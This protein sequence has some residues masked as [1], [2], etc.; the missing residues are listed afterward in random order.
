MSF[1]SDS[2]FTSDPEIYIV[3]LFIQL[4]WFVFILFLE[5]GRI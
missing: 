3:L 1:V 4:F 2:P 5:Q